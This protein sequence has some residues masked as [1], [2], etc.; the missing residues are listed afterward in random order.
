MRE[1]GTELPDADGSEGDDWSEAEGSSWL[2]AYSDDFLVDMGAHSEARGGRVYLVGGGV[3]DPSLLTVRAR[4]LLELCDVVVHDAGMNPALL[5]RHDPGRAPAE[6]HPAHPA[7]E[8]AALLVRLARDGRRV[9]RLTA[10]DPFVM[11]R[12]GIEAEALAEAAVE[13]EVVPGVLPEVVAAAHAGVPLTHPGLSASVTF[14]AYGDDVD[15]PPPDWVAIVR[16]GGTVALQMAASR[17]RA[18]AESLVNAGAAAELPA[19]VVGRGATAGEP[20]LT[21]TL[22]DLATSGEGGSDAPVTLLAGWTAVLRDEL[23]WLERLPLHGRRVAVA[24]NERCPNLAAMAREEGASVVELP[25]A[26][27]EPSDATPLR[28]AMQ[29]LE[30]YEWLVFADA[31]TVRYFWAELRGVGRDARALAGCRLAAANGATEAA[32]MAHG[33]AAD[34]VA[35]GADALL[36]R[37]VEEADISMGRLLWLGPEEGVGGDLH[38]GIEATGAMVET[39]PLYRAA[40][41]SALEDHDTAAVPRASLEHELDGA[42]LPDSSAVRSFVALYGDGSASTIPVVV[43]GAELAEEARTMGL[44]VVIEASD[45]AARPLLSALVEALTG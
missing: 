39:I 8:V 21:T 13:F 18:A 5:S 3:G 28:E 33:L 25:A 34:I 27:R 7:D 41:M 32:L 10:A 15:A 23:A 44:E 37:L 1:D 40:P 26:G 11:G 30:Q 38:Q 35:E 29:W 12:G 16:T 45:A 20:I 36:E 31:P 43:P 2:E 22:G 24:A 4:L 9:V 42:I 6:L 14:A 19:V 17:L